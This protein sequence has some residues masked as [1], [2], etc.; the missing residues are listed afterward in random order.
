MSKPL[1]KIWDFLFGILL[2]GGIPWITVVAIGL[3]CVAM[4]KLFHIQDSD[5]SA[6][7]LGLV[8][9]IAVGISFAWA[10]RFRVRRRLL[11]V[12][13]VALEALLGVAWALAFF[14]LYG[15]LMYTIIS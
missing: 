13:F 9:W 4:E 7:V 3:L 10:I 6:R 8:M 12:G 15:V 14:A 11:P 5:A 2:I 1:A